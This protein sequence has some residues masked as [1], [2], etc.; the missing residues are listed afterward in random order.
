MA[1]RVE[2]GY[3]EQLNEIYHFFSDGI[4]DV[5][6]CH[7]CNPMEIFHDVFRVFTDEKVDHLAPWN[8]N[9][10]IKSHLKYSPNMYNAE[11]Y[12]EECHL[13]EKIAMWH[14]QCG[15][16]D[17][18]SSQDGV[19]PFL[20]SHLMLLDQYYHCWSVTPLTIWILWLRDSLNSR[21]L[22]IITTGHCWAMYPYGGF[23]KYWYP[24]NQKKCT[25]KHSQTIGFPI[26]NDLFCFW[27]S[28]ILGNLHW[29]LTVGSIIFL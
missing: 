16:T 11:S 10:F 18:F 9:A 5:L 1:V 6:C 17:N 21:S 13:H 27:G 8:R 23:L 7:W 12:P 25:P 24:P 3:I 4:Q 29:S 22:I 20:V 26:D 14:V 15:F 28:P 2:P 19:H